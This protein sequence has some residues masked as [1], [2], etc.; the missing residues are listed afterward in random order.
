MQMEIL[1][2]AGCTSW[3]HR[4]DVVQSCCSTSSQ[5]HLPVANPKKNT[6]EDV[7]K[8]EPDNQPL[9]SFLWN[10]FNWYMN[11]AW[12]TKPWFVWFRGQNHRKVMTISYYLFGPNLT[13]RFIRGC[14]CYDILLWIDWGFEVPIPSSKLS[15]IGIKIALIKISLKDQD[16]REFLR[17][18]GC[19]GWKLWSMM[20]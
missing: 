2:F 6:W 17:T 5:G 15:S 13:N 9:F 12:K 7:S 14:L 11:P 19:P 1:S 20:M 18:P 4:I 8:C 10:W 3:H 16:F